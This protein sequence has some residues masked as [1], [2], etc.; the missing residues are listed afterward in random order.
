MAKDRGRVAKI[1]A[2][3][4]EGE[5]IGPSCIRLDEKACSGK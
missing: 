3:V 4:L 1:V 2:S 5:S